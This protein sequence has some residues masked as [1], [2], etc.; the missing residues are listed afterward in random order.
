MNIYNNKGNINLYAHICSL[1]VC[2]LKIWDRN[3]FMRFL[4]VTFVLTRIFPYSV[5]PSTL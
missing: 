5:T 1:Y 3:S 4:C 2:V